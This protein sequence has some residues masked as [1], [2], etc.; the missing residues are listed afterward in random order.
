MNCK[1]CGSPLTVDDQFCKNCGA[2]VDAQ[3]GQNNVQQPTVNQTYQ[4]QQPVNVQPSYQNNGQQVS[5]TGYNQSNYMQQPN[6]SNG[7][8]KQNNNTTKYIIIGVVVV[9]VVIAAVVIIMNMLGGENN[10]NNNSNNANNNN[11]YGEQNSNNNTNNEV[12]NTSNST[13]NVKFGGFTFKIPTDLVYETD[14]DALYIGDEDN[15]WIAAI[16]VVDGSFNQLENN[17]NQLIPLYQQSGYSAA[18]LNQQTYE[19]LDFITL[20]LSFSGQNAILGFARANSMYIFGATMYNLENE[21]DYDLVSNVASVLST[22]EYSG[23]TN[24]ISSFNKADITIIDDLT[25]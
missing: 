16:E 10:D 21:F 23:E 20:E 7:Q 12:N 22:A 18:N 14:I 19:G 1:K 17:K 3:I 13:Y 8:P 6:Q 15:T 2:P 11:N 5:Q 4:A 25:K 9:V 24:N